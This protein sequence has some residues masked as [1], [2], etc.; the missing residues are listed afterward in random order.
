MYVYGSSDGLSDS[1]VPG[2]EWYHTSSAAQNRTWRQLLSRPEL[3]ATDATDT[4]IVNYPFKNGRKALRWRSTV[5]AA[6]SQSSTG[7][8]SGA[9]STTIDTVDR[10]RFPVRCTVKRQ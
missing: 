2:G 9:A 10:A 4:F 7:T 5:R 6:T 8:P 3:S 1:A